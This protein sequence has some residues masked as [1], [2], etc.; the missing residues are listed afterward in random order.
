MSDFNKLWLG[1]T[2]SLLGSAVTLFA[3]PT[4]AVLVLHATALQV[5]ALTALETLPFPVLGMLVGVIADRVSRRR[6]M[7][8]ADVVRL[9]ALASIPLAALGKVLAMPQLYAVA[10]I[11]GSASAFFGISYQA[12]LPVLVPRERLTDANAKLEF[13][14]SGSAMAGRA[15]AGVLVQWI[16]AAFALAV[17]AAS[18]LVSVI[19]LL[20][21]RKHE[22]AHAG[23]PLTP[24]QAAR[25]M[26]EGLA[27]VF[28]SDDLRWILCAT[29]TTNFGS[30]MIM[31]V[32]FIFAYRILHVQPGLLGV[33]DGFANVG[34]IGAILAVRIRSRFGLRITL[35]G[36]LFASGAAS[37]AI[38]LAV[39]GAPYVVL[40]VQGAIFA[41]AVPIYNVNQVSY[42]QGLIDVRLQGR[43]NAT[44]RTFVW[45]TLPLGS[46]AGGWLGTV[47]GVQTTIAIGGLLACAAAVWIL[48][49]R[50]R[51]TAEAC[52]DSK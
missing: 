49:L 47:A 50:S 6:I 17:D 7:I 1:Q 35:M 11:T 14:N 13:S 19:S 34:F 8:G 37:L 41:I 48:P 27:V 23:P 45:G 42:R 30:A 15:F 5:G 18:Y 4:L 36:A 44:M 16:G 32:F 25:E 2:V 20:T 3:L 22:P 31:A 12:Y 33:V 38:L 21:I 43:M 9:A 52:P 46:I 24:R 39:L 10:L 29:A 51:P 28:K 26:R 40:F